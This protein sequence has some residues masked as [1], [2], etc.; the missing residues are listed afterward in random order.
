MTSQGFQICQRKSA[1]D[2]TLDVQ[3]RRGWIS[4][5][6]THIEQYVD[7]SYQAGRGCT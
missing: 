4:L 1:A 5:T 6:Q 3:T 7:N 2:D